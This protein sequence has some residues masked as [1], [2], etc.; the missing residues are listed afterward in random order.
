M[1]GCRSPGES[2]TTS[3]AEP[4]SRLVKCPCMFYFSFLSNLLTLL[5]Q[6]LAAALLHDWDHVVGIEILEGL[7][8]ASLELLE[9]WNAEVKPHLPPAAQ[10]TEIEFICDDVTKRDWSDADMWFANSTCFDE[11]VRCAVGMLM[12][13]RLTCCIVLPVDEQACNHCRQD[14]CRNILCDVHQAPSFCEV[15]SVG[16]SSVHDVVGQRHRLHPAE[17]PL[18]G[19]GATLVARAR[20]RQATCR[21]R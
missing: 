9:R 18:V 17:G 19:S 21:W 7:H 11:V 5:L 3:A 16:A 12:D 1:A 6:A 13:K 20:R 15:A 14:A 4:A 8:A 10:K 2:F